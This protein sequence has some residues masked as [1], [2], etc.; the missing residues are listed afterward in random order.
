MMCE[1]SSTAGMGYAKLPDSKPDRRALLQKMYKEYLLG[2][3]IDLAGT[4][5]PIALTGTHSFQMSRDMGVR[6][7]RLPPAE[8]V[9]PA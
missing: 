3:S 7:Y 1:F 4:D 2:I 6:L 5:G 9:H 8:L